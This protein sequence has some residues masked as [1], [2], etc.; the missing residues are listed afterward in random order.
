MMANVQASQVGLIGAGRMGVAIG[1]RLLDLGER[2]IVWNRSPDKAA[3]LLE[4]GAILAASPA[5]VAR[6]TS[7]M[8]V[9]VRDDNA[10]AQVYEG[11]GGLLS[12]SMIDRTVVEMTTGTVG[13]MTRMA[14]LVAKQGGAFVDAPVSGTITPA[15]AGQLV[16]M[17][18]GTTEALGRARPLLEKLSRK[19]VHAGPV[20][21]GMAMKLVLN[22]PLAIYWEGLGE[23][24]AMGRAYGLDI[25]TMLSLICDSKVAVGALAGKLP[26]IL[27]E[28]DRV[29]FD[30][31]GMRKDLAAMLSS[32]DAVGVALPAARVAA[33]SASNA[34][35]AGLGE[36]DL[37]TVV[38]FVA[39]ME[40]K[41]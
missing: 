3:A 23:A 26:I 11:T 21:S 16:V 34:I 18:G 40:A 25:A 8:I 32:A 31:A 35:D 41:S 30:V 6:Q 12:Q 36:R 1:E 5:D 15:R 33:Q 22:L 37:A 7:V 2:L 4:R 29:E 28:T 14:A 10:M 27:G 39:G 19:I 13:A 9:I 38:R 24:L 17:A 20:G